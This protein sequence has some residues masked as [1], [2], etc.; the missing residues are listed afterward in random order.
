MKAKSIIILSFVGV[1]AYVLADIFHEVAGHGGTCL[2]IGNKIDLITS[3][4]FKSS[5]GSFLTDIGGPVANLLFGLLIH[6]FLARR[7]SLSL[8]PTLFLLHILAYNLFWFSGTILQSGFSN[9]GDWT[10][11][12]KEL[13]IG[14]FGKPVLV[15][16]G[17]IAY[18]LSIKIVRLHINKAGIIFSEFSL[19]QSI[20]CSYLAAVIAAIITGLFFKPDRIQAAFEGLLE[21]LGSLPILFINRGTQPKSNN[22]ELKANLIVIASVFIFFIT[23][24]FTLGRG[25]S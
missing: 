13:K 6:T 3:V 23:F 14:I 17:V 7:K 12:I 25:I 20:V 9:A 5:P 11:A 16:A 15:M 22:Y 10:Y 1:A 24:C 19:R 21:M 2:I 8:L 4:Y 18:F